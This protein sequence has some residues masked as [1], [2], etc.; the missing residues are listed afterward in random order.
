[1][2]MFRFFIIVC[3]LFL[4]AACDQNTEPAATDTPRPTSAPSATLTPEIASFATPDPALNDGIVISNAAAT[5]ELDENS[6]AVGADT[7]FPEDSSVIYLTAEATV[8][9]DTAI[10]VRLFR[11]SSPLQDTETIIADQDYADICIFFEFTHDRD[12][13]F[14]RRGEYTAQIIANDLLRARINF[15]VE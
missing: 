14:F 15:F 10:F 7:R 4:L 9:R 1:M 3:V 13:G 8:P 6:C 12:E 2:F 11:N 5:T